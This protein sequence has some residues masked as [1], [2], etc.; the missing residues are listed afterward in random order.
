[1]A[2]SARMAGH[3]V[4]MVSGTDEHGTPILVQA[5]QDGV[6]PQTLADRY[7]QVIVQD[8]H[9]LG[10]S[11][12]LFTRT[13]TRNHYQVVQQMFKQVHQ[14]G[15]LVEQTTMGAVSPSTG[16]AL[17]DRF[18]EGTCPICSYDSA[19][20]DQCDNCGNQLDPIDLIN[21]RSKINGETPK[22]AKSEH[23]F[24]DLPALTEA[25][26]SWL[27]QRQN[28]RPNVLKFSLNLLDEVRPRAMTRDIDWGIPVP[29]AGWDNQPG[30]RIYVWF[31]AVVGYLSASIEWARRQALAGQG[32]G[33]QW[34]EWWNN[35][36]AQAHYFMGKDNITFHSQI[37][38]AELLGYRGLGG[39]G[40]QAGDFGE[41]ELPTEVVSSEFL[42]ME[43]KQFSS[44]RGVVI[45]V[46]DMLE[47]YQADALRYFIAVAG[48]ENQDAD[49][50]WSE[51]KRRTNDELVA[52]WGNLVN[53]TV[54]LIHKNF[55]AIPPPP[56]Q[57]QAVDSAIL[58]AAEAG[59]NEVNSLIAAHHQKAGITAA[60]KVVASV[61]A[62]LAQTTPWLLAKGGGCRDAQVA[63]Q[64][65]HRPSPV[66]GPLLQQQPGLG[67]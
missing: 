57:P 54:N 48:P 41:L 5:E 24:L 45:Y 40:G 23:L 9:Q 26:G 27:G 61:N 56:G 21:P 67:R 8:L 52:A 17:P 63:G 37:W 49:F 14:N 35:P 51:F 62:Y 16:R 33:E 46:R 66:A 20:G 18:I 6:S 58:Q 29:L 50:T 64:L 65:K 55:G 15:Y 42:T 38:P 43:G 2:R 12:D 4:L 36:Q 10:L 19:R 1:F 25:L 53:R 30:K 47:R 28:W 32:D 59:L 7:N 34:R 31:D 39:R 3:Q 13:T 22:F 44:S 60:L 11:Y